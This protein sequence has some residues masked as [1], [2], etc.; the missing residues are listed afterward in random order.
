MSEVAKYTF[1]VKEGQPSD[2]GAHEAPVY[3][4]CEPE[5]QGLSIVG[6]GSLTLLLRPGATVSDAQTVAGYLQQ[7]VTRIGFS[8]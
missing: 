7:F 6:H 5:S 8:P 1:R 2:N 3:L 4:L